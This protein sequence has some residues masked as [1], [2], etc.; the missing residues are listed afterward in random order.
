MFTYST[1]FNNIP[2]MYPPVA[3]RK[4]IPPS[5]SGG[6]GQLA[7]RATPHHIGSGPAG[8]VPASGRH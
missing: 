7:L 1:N 4:P 5:G 2:I 6:P 3:D 8:A